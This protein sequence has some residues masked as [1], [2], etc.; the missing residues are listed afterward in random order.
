MCVALP[1]RVDRIDSRTST[2]IPGRAT[3]GRSQITVD[4]ILVPEVAVGDYVIVHSGYAI[5]IVPEEEAEKSRALLR[6]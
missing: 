1:A 4:L 6:S 3:V 5:A 2:S